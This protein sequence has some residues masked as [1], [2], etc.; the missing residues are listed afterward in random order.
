MTHSKRPRDRFRAEDLHAEVTFVLAR[1]VPEAPHH[2]MGT[3]IINRVQT[4][5]ELRPQC[6]AL[7][8]QTS[9]EGYANSPSSK[10][11]AGNCQPFAPPPRPSRESA[12]LLS[13]TVYSTFFANSFSIE[14]APGVCGTRAAASSQ[15]HT[16]T[17]APR[18]CATLRRVTTPI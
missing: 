9:K 5:G 8:P 6:S 1:P 7:R 16:P 4:S 3:L 14:N 12:A 10:T 18:L 11:Q 15:Q 2:A 17:P 13:C